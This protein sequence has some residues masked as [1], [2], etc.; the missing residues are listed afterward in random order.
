[1]DADSLPNGDGLV[2][3][4][5][6]LNWSAGH[7]SRSCTTHLRTSTASIKDDSSNL[8]DLFERLYEHGSELDS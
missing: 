7:P 2:D 8:E 4:F 5:E 3:R 6:A 1:M